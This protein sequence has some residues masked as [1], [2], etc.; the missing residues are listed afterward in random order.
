MLVYQR[1]IH[2]FWG[3]GQAHAVCFRLV[4]ILQAQLMTDDSDDGHPTL[5][6]KPQ[7]QREVRLK[8][9]QKLPIYGTFCIGT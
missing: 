7:P 2:R 5:E 6:D 4:R 3:F 8:M 9:G 1:V